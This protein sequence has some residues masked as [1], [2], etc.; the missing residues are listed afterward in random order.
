MCAVDPVVLIQVKNHSGNKKFN[1]NDHRYF[2]KVNKIN[3]LNK[4]NL[5]DVFGICV[6]IIV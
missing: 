3:S 1:Y 2:K 6:T 5:V 4:I